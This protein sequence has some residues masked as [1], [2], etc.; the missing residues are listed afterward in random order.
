MHDVGSADDDESGP[1]F[2]NRTVLVTFLGA[3]VRQMGG[4]MP[5]TGTIELMGQ[6]GIDPNSARTSI[7]RL[8]KRGWLESQ[9]ASHQRG[10]C[11]TS[12]AADALAAGDAV[13]WHARKPADLADGWCIV[14]F[15]V[16]E[17][18]RARRHQLRSHLAALGFGNIGTAVWIAP[19]RMRPAAELAVA[20]LGLGQYSAVFVGDH[21][22][23]KDLDALI[24]DGWDL[25]A[26]N[27]RYSDFLDRFADEAAAG[28]EAADLRSAF[29]SYIS[30]VDHW[31][32]LPYRDPGLPPEVLPEGW[33][34][35]AAVEVFETLVARHEGRALAH[36]ATH[37]PSEAP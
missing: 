34:G 33:A 7:F 1:T 14:H 5:T 30:V 24:R 21:V 16:P 22:G 2:R 17:S 29:S 15:S 3:V 27:Q 20:E 11:L 9:A 23:G 26:I 28:S 31:R 8:K 13:I 35:P 6:C 32:R 4:W 10:Y 36:A 25:P 19:A 37:W 12:L 18:A